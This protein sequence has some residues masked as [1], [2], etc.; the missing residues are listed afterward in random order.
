MLFI[1]VAHTDQRNEVN[2]KTIQFHPVVVKFTWESMG[3]VDPQSRYVQSQLSI[4]FN[5][6]TQLHL[7]K[8]SS[9]YSVHLLVGQ[10]F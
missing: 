5:P 7:Y 2:Y 9:F 3:K 1:L 8:C 6:N 4:H 10:T